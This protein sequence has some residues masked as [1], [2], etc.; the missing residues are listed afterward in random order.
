[1]SEFNLRIPGPVPLPP[2]VKEALAEDMIDH[3]GPEFAALFE[4]IT[5]GLKYVFQTHHDVLILTAS[6]TGGL[7]AALVNVLSPGER[8][9]VVVNGFFGERWFE[10]AR[11]FG[12]EAIPLHFPP[13]SGA[14]P[15]EIRKALLKAYPC[16]ALL[17]IHNETSTGV[18]ND[19]KAIAEAAQS[20]EDPPLILVDAVSSLGA[21]DLRPDEW[22]CDVVVTA[23][24]KALMAPPG[25]SLIS[26]SPRAWENSEK[27]SLPRFYWD[28]RKFREYA[29]HHQTPFTPALSALFGLRESLKLIQEEG[30]EKVFAR[31]R[32]IA[33][34]TR[35]G[36]KSLGLSLFPDERWASNTVTAV[37]VPEGLKAEEIIRHLREEHAIV[38]A[39]GQG[40]LKGKILRIAHIGRVSPEE[41][42]QVIEALGKVLKCSGCS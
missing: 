15:E 41:M 1:M 28:F 16:K 24:Q 39:G 21:I 22:G 30:L 9:L 4:E 18:T 17:I 29:S 34:F 12:L 31:H 8:V 33:E 37:R 32:S 40:E 14:D 5:R 7:E 10:M 11:A 38:V 36:I 35:Q 3:R 13:G 23:S 6:G 27:A 2:E 26:V 25:L 42:A 20:V 19:L